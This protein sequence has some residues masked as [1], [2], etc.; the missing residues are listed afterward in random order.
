ML[1]DNTYID[2]AGRLCKVWKFM[3]VRGVSVIGGVDD[4]QIWPEAITAQ[5][6]DSVMVLEPKCKY[7]IRLDLR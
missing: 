4:V 2:P 6:A 7:N 5:P 3:K 1:S